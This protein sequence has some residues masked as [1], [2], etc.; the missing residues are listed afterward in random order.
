MHLLEACYNCHFD[1]TKMSKQQLSIE[2]KLSGLNDQLEAIITKAKAL[3]YDYGSLIA[4]VHPSYHECALNLTHYLAFR[5]FNIDQ[6]QEELRFMGLPDLGNIEGH[7]M[8]SLL[9]VKSIINLFRGHPVLETQK[10]IISIK[11]SSKLLNKNTR[12]LFGYKS[13]RRQTRIMVTLPATAADDYSLVNHL[14]SLGMNSARINCAH[15]SPD[16]WSKMIQNIYRAK[17]TLNKNCKIIMDLGGPKLRTGAMK[18]GPMVIHIKPKRDQIGRVIQPARVWIAPPDIPPPDNTADAILPVDERFLRRIKRGNTIHFIDSRGK[19]CKIEIERKKGKGKWGLCSDSAYI[20]TGTEINLNKIKETGNA[21]IYVGE[22]LPIEQFITLHVGDKLILHSDPTPGEPAEY[23]ENGSLLRHAHISCTL[24]EIFNDLNPLEPVFLNDGKIEAV[25]ESVNAKEILLNITYAQRNGGKLRADKGINIPQSN[26]QI[27][28]LTAKDKKDLSFVARMA[29]VVNLS[30]VNQ[31]SDVQEYLK[32]VNKYDAQPG[33]ILKIETQKGFKNLPEILM[34]AMQTFPVGVMIA[35]GDLAIETG[36][37]NFAS[38][39]EEIMRI[40][41]AAL[42]P[43]VWATQVLDNMAKKGIPTRSEITDAAFSQRAECVM[44]NK[45]PYIEK[46]VKTLDKILRR[47]QRFQNKK[48]TILPRM[49]D[50]DK[51]QL[52]HDN[53][54]V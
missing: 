40:S 28:G 41:E 36:W 47:M 29:D 4:R 15:D 9:A 8:K 46:T 12:R 2:E 22:Q 45:G 7:V 31:A 19:K 48:L 51:M 10:G 42:V 44:L 18:P 35:R 54:N 21:R 20:T 38:I 24:P 6:L 17:D 39:Q 23:A 33:L 34:N 50:A 26:L 14:M 30:F 25:I 16:V 5:S 43:V 32:E 52:S 3:E 27:S 1:E 11:K 49:E 53:F 13:K 37:K